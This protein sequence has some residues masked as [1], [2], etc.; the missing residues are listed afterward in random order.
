MTYD[1]SKINDAESWYT[2]HARPFLEKLKPEI[3][4]NLDKDLASLIK[5]AA[6]LPETFSACVLGNSGVGKS[7]LINSIVDGRTTVLPSGGIGPLTAQALTVKYSQTPKLEIEYH[8]P[9]NFWRLIFG[10][11][12]S[13]ANELFSSNPDFQK[14]DQE[15]SEQPI[16]TNDQ[17]SEE[18]PEAVADNRTERRKTIQLMI[19]G[20][21]DIETEIPYLVD[22]MRQALGKYR[23]MDTEAKQEDIER[24]NRIAEALS[25]AKQKK[26][27][28]YELNGNNKSD[29]LKELRNHASGFLAPLI[30]NLTVFWPSEILAKGVTLVDL[31][32]VGISGDVH[33]EVTRKWIREKSQAI[34]LVVDHRGITE[35]VAQLLR[36]SEFLTRLMY[37]ADDPIDDPV[38]IVAVTKLD[39]IAESARTDEKQRL[40]EVGLKPRPLREHFADECQKAISMIRGQVRQ[41]LENFVSTSNSEVAE[42][43]KMVIENIL[44]TLE[45]FPVSAL[46]YRKF[47]ANDDDDKSF[48]SSEDQSNIPTLQRSLQNLSIQ[49]RNAALEKLNAS[50]SLFLERTS[51]QVRVLMEKWEEETRA[52]EEADE[53]REQLN[54]FMAPLREKLLIRQGEYRAFLKDS[55]PTRIEDLVDAALAKAETEINQYLSTLGDAHWATL[56][57]SVR[58][59]GVHS[60]VREIDLPREFAYRVEEPIADAWGKKILKEIRIKTKEYGDNIVE[61]VGQVVTWATQQKAHIKTRVIQAQFDSIKADVSSLNTVGKEIINELRDKVKNQLIETI[62][63]PIRKGCQ[64][65]INQNN[66]IGIGVK[67]RILELY[68]QLAKQVTDV[69]DYDAKDILRS[70]FHEVRTE[71]LAAFSEHKNPL[72]DAANA[73]VATQEDYIKRS[74]RQRKKSILEE[75]R[76]VMNALSNIDK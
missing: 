12:S 71:V 10:F 25:I 32:G 7:T 52:K 67:R 69:V 61:L 19:K 64:N 37:T 3:L 31:P 14:I 50:R 15:S 6:T 8:S 45:I 70:L 39:D 75:A 53:L 9:L 54:I 58:K 30:K 13:Y 5:K 29:F 47:L 17:K 26:T 57:A 23:I 34:V 72:E 73:I 16:D 43:Q 28:T 21:Q 38:L 46:Q 66:H 24:I 18:T 11:E 63:P 4:N 60:G 76:V 62:E 2:Q 36:S 42:T 59:E 44:K 35:A 20:N 1:I 51:T 48:I 27:K 33:R 40:S 56:K 49:R 22:C 41:Q 65:F 55:I 74:D 68:S